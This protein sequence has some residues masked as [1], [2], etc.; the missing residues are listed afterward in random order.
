MTLTKREI[1]LKNKLEF[2]YQAFDKSKI[3][4]DPIEF[5]H[6]Y[7]DD[8]DIEISALISSLFA[9]GNIKQIINT[10]ERIHKIMGSTVYD[11]VLNYNSSKNY[12][13]DIRHRFYT[14]NDIENLF[15]ALKTLY[16]NYKSAELFF[17]NSNTLKENISFF[18]NQM[19]KYTNQKSNL[20]LGIKFMFPDPKKGSACKR[21]NLFL[22]W[23][24][25]KDEIDF[26][27]WKNISKSELIIP[28]DTHIAKIAYKLKLTN[29][30]N[31]T[32]KMAEEITDN[33]KK[34]DSEDPVKYDFALCHLGIRK[35]EF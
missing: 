31:V 8:S 5:P 16:L 13:K 34:F 26:G 17:A 4:P 7:N 29:R 33:L 30:K 2:H 21:M 14:T 27:L 10:L 18:S 3:S 28:V 35:L 12:F 11:F 20:S 19:I 25:R 15:N 24:V 9:F 6:R 32:W 22:R 23:M 1:E